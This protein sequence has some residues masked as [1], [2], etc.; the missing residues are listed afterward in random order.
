MQFKG[1]GN[2]NIKG[3]TLIELSIVIVI[4]G[5]I[6]AGVVGGQSLVK[7][8][9]L[10]AV[11]TEVSQYR[12]AINTF[13]L[14]YDYLPGD[15]P[16]AFAYWGSQNGCTNS[17]VV[18]HISN[19]NGCNGDGNKRISHWGGEGYRAWQ[20]LALAEIIA[21]TYTGRAATGNGNAEIGIT[22]PASKRSNT[23]FSL[24]APGNNPITIVAGGQ[25][26]GPSTAKTFTPKEAQSLDI[27]YDDGV[28]GTGIFIGGNGQAG[29]NAPYTG[30]TAGVCLNAGEYDLALD[31]QECNFTYIF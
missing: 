1:S 13:K 21:G 30:I 26:G 14:E 7:Q 15:I 17:I 29:A 27:K 8:A 12:V 18:D 22:V 11:M 25:R 3:F 10:K 9:N 28:A 31:S 4:I 6:V 24:Y 23:G 5:L 19:P 2:K 16:N 20:H